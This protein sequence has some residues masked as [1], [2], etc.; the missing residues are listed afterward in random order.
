MLTN[1]K[2]DFNSAVNEQWAVISDKLKTLAALN[3]EEERALAAVRGGCTDYGSQADVRESYRKRRASIADAAMERVEKM[4]TSLRDVLDG[5]L[6]FD[7]SEV[8]AVA[9]ALA[10]KG[11]T[12]DDMRA[13]AKRN[14]TK[15]GALLAIAET[16]GT[17]A[18][19]VGVAI[20]HYTKTL[21]SACTKAVE[22]C[23]R[24]LAGQGTQ[25]HAKLRSSIDG[26]SEAIDEAWAKLQDAIDSKPS[27]DPMEATLRRL[28]LRG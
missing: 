17:Y 9:P 24:S 13:L 20:D 14:R 4:R 26:R 16:G 2:N 19:K 25:D 27:V 6:A 11:L 15:R 1:A 23:E 5:T 18:S 12:D 10:L 3:A 22:S 21:S 28:A 7:A 8:T